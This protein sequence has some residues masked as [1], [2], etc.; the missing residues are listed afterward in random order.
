MERINQTDL[1]PITSGVLI[2]KERNS[3]KLSSKQNDVHWKNAHVKI[4]MDSDSS[5]SIIHESY[6]R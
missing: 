3:K 4:L 1:V 5:A 2:R 6:V